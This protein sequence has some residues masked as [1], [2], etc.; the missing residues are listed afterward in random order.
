MTATEFAKGILYLSAGLNRP[1]SDEALEPYFDLL[2]DLD[3]ETFIKACRAVLLTHKWN[4]FP[5]IAELR[6]AAFAVS[7]PSNQLTAGEAFA[8]A[9]EAAGNVDMDIIGP[10]RVRNY[11]TGEWEIYPS[12]EAYA[13]RDVPAPI[14]QAMRAFGLREFCYATDPTGVVRAQFTKV[15]EQITARDQRTALMPPS[16]REFLDNK[17]DS[18]L[19][20]K[21]LS[22]IGEMSK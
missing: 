10:Y 20:Q 6:E 3:Y 13:L 17:R 7:G 8:I 2:G 5:T 4:T 1:M 19:V 11:K 16:V 22:Q 14:V 9:R 18:D 21:S 15:F 12:Q